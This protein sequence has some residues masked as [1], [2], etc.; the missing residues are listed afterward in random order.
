[1]VKKESLKSMVKNSSEYN[2]AKKISKKVLSD[3]KKMKY[4][5]ILKKSQIVVNIPNRKVPSVL[6][7]PNRFF[8]SEMEDAKKSMFIEWYS[9]EN[10]GGEMKNE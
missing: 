3:K 5:R 8:K 10:L 7:D 1:M 6:N 4:K 9:T 2:I